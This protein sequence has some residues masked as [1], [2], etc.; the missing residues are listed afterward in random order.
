MAQQKLRVLFLCTGNS[1]RSQMAEALL[2]HHGKNRFDAFSAG[3]HPEGVD[4]RTIETLS[5]A[6]ISSAGLTSKAV[7]TYEG[8]HF[9]FVIA[10]CD[11]AHQRCPYWPGSGHVLDWG[12]SDPKADTNANGFARS[13]SAIEERIR[14]FIEVNSKARQQYSALTAIGFYK[15]LADELRLKML[16]M[17]ERNNELCVCDLTEALG[18]SQ[19]KV[20][21]HLAQL[22][23]SGVLSDRRQGQWV[24]YRLHPAMPQWMRDVITLTAEANGVLFKECQQKL[25]HQSCES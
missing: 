10:L 7:E 1:A 3:T 24:Y 2:R 17:I 4:P 19:P 21:R 18:E 6:G 9:D 15:S 12:F 14:M 20:S 25:T 22:R 8:Q 16:L 13:L 23:K 11:N 5:A